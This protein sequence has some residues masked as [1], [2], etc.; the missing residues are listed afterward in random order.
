MQ[1]SFDLEKNMITVRSHLLHSS[2]KES[3]ISYI[4]G[5]VLLKLQRR[6]CSIRCISALT[7]SSK[8]GH[9]NSALIKRKDL[10]G[11]IYPSQ[12]TIAVC[13]ETE[14]VY[15]QLILMDKVK[16]FWSGSFLG[17]SLLNCV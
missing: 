10:G 14:R 11:L 15:I 13:H 3:M 4:T 1:F 8:V 7:D 12:D 2:F 5:F 9:S 17:R 6:L 16:I